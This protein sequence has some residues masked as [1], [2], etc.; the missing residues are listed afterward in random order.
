MGPRTHSF[1]ALGSGYWNSVYYCKLRK[2]LDTTAIILSSGPRNFHPTLT[3]FWEVNE[4]WNGTANIDWRQM[5]TPY[6]CQIEFQFHSWKE[7][8]KVEGT[9]DFFTFLF[10]YPKS[11]L[12][13]PNHHYSRIMWSIASTK[14]CTSVSLFWDATWYIKERWSSHTS[15]E[16]Q[17]L[18]FMKSPLLSSQIL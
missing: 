14:W 11:I 18:Q 13:L 10:L 17:T 16:G 1:G 3:S 6:P 2:N 7:L 9:L 12:S 4:V 8:V 15:W 5:Q